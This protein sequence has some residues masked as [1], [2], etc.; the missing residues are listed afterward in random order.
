MSLKEEASLRRCSHHVPLVRDDTAHN[1]VALVL[2]QTVGILG[3]MDEN[4]RQ[5]V[6]N[7]DFRLNVN[8][9][10]QIARAT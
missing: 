4:V 6:G 1:Q 3:Q 10:K 5:D 2:D 9:T 7:N 8:A